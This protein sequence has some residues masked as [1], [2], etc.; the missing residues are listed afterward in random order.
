LFFFIF[1]SA[2]QREG[3]VFS[4]CSYINHFRRCIFVVKLPKFTNYG[5]LQRRLFITWSSWR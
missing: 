3:L 4:K 1:F 5:R 2:A